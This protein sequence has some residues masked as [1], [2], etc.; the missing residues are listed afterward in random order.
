MV[1]LIDRI[2]AIDGLHAIFP[3]ATYYAWPS[4]KAFGL[5]SEEFATHAL[6][7]EGVLVLPGT[8]FG[9]GGEGYIRLAFSF[10]PPEKCYEGARLLAGAMLA[11]RAS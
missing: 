9:R 1:L 11:A 5:T 2:N 3:D 4:I 10:E 6:L 7:S 8:T